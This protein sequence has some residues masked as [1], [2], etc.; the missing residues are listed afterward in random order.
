MEK[1]PN[2]ETNDKPA[3]EKS[4]NERPESIE[5]KENLHASLKE[6][7][8]DITEIREVLESGELDGRELAEAAAAR[9]DRVLGKYS[10]AAQ[11]KINAI[12]P[13]IKRKEEI[14]KIFDERIESG[15][16]DVSSLI[17]ES[18]RLSQEI[19]KLNDDPNV[20]L[21]FTLRRGKESLLHKAEEYEAAKRN[22]AGY[23]LPKKKGLREAVAGCEPIFSGLSVSYIMAGEKMNGLGYDCGTQGM[24]F[25]KSPVNLVRNLGDDG[26]NKEVLDH[27]AVHAIYEAFLWQKADGEREIEKD[28]D[29]YKRLAGKEGSEY[30]LRSKL[31]SLPER[32]RE[33]V[34]SAK[35]ELIA[36]FEELVKGNLHTELSEFRYAIAFLRSRGKS[37]KPTEDGKSGLV[38]E[39]LR[40]YER[41]LTDS[42]RDFY[43]ELGDLFF[44][45]EREGRLGELKSAMILFD[46]GEYRKI[47]RFFKDEIGREKYDLYL[48]LRRLT[49]EPFFNGQST[50]EERVMDEIYGRTAKMSWE[51]EA[52]AVINAIRS[53]P[54]FLTDKIKGDLAGVLKAVED[55]PK[56]KLEAWRGAESCE[57]ACGII[58]K[59]G[60][61]SG[62]DVAEYLKIAVDDCLN[63]AFED[64]SGGDMKK[65]NETLA[66]LGPEYDK[67]IGDFFTDYAR[68]AADD[69]GGKEALFSSALWQE[70]R[71]NER[72]RDLARRIEE[73]NER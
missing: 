29:L 39:Y 4:V 30:L 24:H 41:R 17:E 63:S 70:A 45:A 73:L 42:F 57:I 66:K 51:E 60:E 59:I 58:R 38:G 14:E 52:G 27:E 21:V 54:E 31:E 26:K 46:P 61:I 1:W 8:G 28:A 23:P 35:G 67:F 71:N 3:V 72:T 37:L 62:I 13:L 11:E 43:K 7:I 64:A 56:M 40:E 50:G 5:K 12:G 47:G 69:F 55:N 25:P 2:F 9:I 15:S 20:R 33:F 18:E 16:G 49:R 6:R 68:E 10:P 22:P 36:N 65:L 32:A 53:N 48:S 34:Y 44:I 19:S